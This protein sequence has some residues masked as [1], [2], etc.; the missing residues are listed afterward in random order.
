MW[1]SRNYVTR[2]QNKELTAVRDIERDDLGKVSNFALYITSF[3]VTLKLYTYKNS[4]DR[5]GET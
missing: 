3:L 4:V 1:L 5:G 2:R